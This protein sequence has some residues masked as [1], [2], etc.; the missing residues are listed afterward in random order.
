MK[1]E[2]CG[3]NLGIEEEICPYCGK[4]NR[5]AKK[6]I[7]DMHKY[8][9][10]FNSTRE[11]VLANSRRFSAFIVRLTVVAILVALVAVSFVIYFNRYELETARKERDVKRHLGQYR[12][13]IETMMDDR[14]YLSLESYMRV[15]RLTYS[16]QL[17]EYYVVY[18]AS[19]AYHSFTE[20][21]AY[22]LDEDSFMKDEEAIEQ[23][24]TLLERLYG[25]ASPTSEYEI[26]KYYNNEVYAYIDDL[27][28]HT[29]ILVRGYFGLSEEDMESFRTLSRA[30]KQVMLEEGYAHV[31]K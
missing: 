23:I 27:T 1:C 24:A 19:A 2:N 7:R 18:N 6:H 28:A 14:D 17:D 26:K 21:M 12:A 31:G 25:Y 4:E 9:N 15:N 13:K 16:E 30:R 3:N 22:L 20:Y 29:E 11:E 5:F 10:S 8:N